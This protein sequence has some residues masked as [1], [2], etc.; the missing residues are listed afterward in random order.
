[1]WRRHG[2]RRLSGLDLA[3]TLT[4]A[5]LIP[6]ALTLAIPLAI[7]FFLAQP[8]LFALLFLALALKQLPASAVLLPETRPLISKGRDVNTKGRKTHF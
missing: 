4:P 8:P 3:L 5:P 6:P 1:M 2:R 7:F